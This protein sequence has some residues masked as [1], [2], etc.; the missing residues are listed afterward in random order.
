MLTEEVVDE[1]ERPPEFGSVGAEIDI[2]DYLLEYERPHLYPKQM[3][4][5]FDPKRYSA[6]EAST[7]AGKT[8]GCIAWIFEKALYGREGQNF[9]WVAP[10][11]GQADI[12][13]RRCLR[14]I[15]P[16]VGTANLTLKTITLINGAI[17]WF[18]SA[19]KPDSLYGEDVH[20]AV[21]DEAS[22]VKEPAW[23][24]VRSTLTATRGQIRLIGNVKGRK[25]WFYQIARKGEKGD[26]PSIGFHKITAIDA[27]AAGVLDQEEIDDAERLLPEAVF[28]ELYLAEPSDDGGNPFG[29]QHIKKCVLPAIVESQP[30]VFGIDVARK[31]DY[32]VAT[33]LDLY[34]RVCRF[35]RSGG[36]APSWE[37][38][39]KGVAGVV[40]TTPA[41]VEENGVG[42]PVLERLQK[43]TPGSRYEGYTTTAA[44]K[45]RLMEGL[46]VA[47]QKGEVGFPDGPIRQELEQFEF[48]YTR[49]GVRYSA[50][51]GFHDDCVMSLALAVEHKSH[52]RLPMKVN[53]SVLLRAR[54][55]GRRRAS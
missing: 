31:L 3:A 39:Y 16:D 37:S 53:S 33:G 54:A 27:V 14:A 8:A 38:I 4:A 45:Q 20:A 13:F 29:L 9:W 52:A 22:R 15:P 5:I 49:T 17:I 19:D 18:K 10:V 26:D 32:T 11:S 24:A 46:A 34:G 36:G 7:K 55:M 1:I 40:K 30:V 2:D 23:W 48:E 51:E 25:N 35:F 44:S 50:P 21:I 41:L 42:D 28:R 6:I 12:A 47:I 43:D